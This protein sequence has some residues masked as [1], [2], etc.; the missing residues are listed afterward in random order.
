MSEIKF[1]EEEL[2]QVGDLQVKYNEI[3]NKLGQLSIARLNVNK[4]LELLGDQ[5]DGLH[6]ELESTQGTEQKLLTVINKKYGP[7]QLD[8][9]TG[10]FTPSDQ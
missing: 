4:Q 10:I 9:S 3:T 7:G 6:A 5:E 2:K 8:A 1:T